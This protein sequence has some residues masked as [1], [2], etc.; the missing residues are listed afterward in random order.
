MK[1]QLIFT[2]LVFFLSG[3]FSNITY[4]QTKI[5]YVYD[6]T[7]NRKIRKLI[8]TPCSNCLTNPQTGRAAEKQQDTT[9]ALI[10]QHEINVFPNPTQDKVN[11]TLGNLKDDEITEAIVTDGSGKILFTQKNLKSQNEINMAS[12]SNG[13]YFFRV[14]IGKDVAVYKVMKFQ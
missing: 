8:V 11:L 9:E 10:A 6:Q 13:T 4:A 3:F 12:L 1:T 7:G 14:T 5:G 2:V